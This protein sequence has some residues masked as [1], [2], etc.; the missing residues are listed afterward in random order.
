[1]IYVAFS[2][3]IKDGETEYGSDCVASIKAN[4]L[5]PRKIKETLIREVAMPELN[6]N[7]DDKDEYEIHEDDEIEAKNGDY[8]WVYVSQIKPMPKAHFD[9]MIKYNICAYHELLPVSEAFQFR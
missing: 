1:M 7:P 4:N 3:T 6:I 9:I 8:R 2:I 5:T